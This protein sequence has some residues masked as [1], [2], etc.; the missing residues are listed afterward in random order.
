[1]FILFGRMGHN[2]LIVT[3]ATNIAIVA[4]DGLWELTPL[5]IFTMLVTAYI[6]HNGRATF[7]GVCGAGWVGRTK[8]YPLDCY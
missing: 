2:P 7:Y 4:H 1:M 6:A 8:H 5:S 3:T